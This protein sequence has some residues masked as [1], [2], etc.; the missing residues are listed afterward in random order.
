[1]A[2]HSRGYQGNEKYLALDA[3]AGK[4]FFLHMTH[5]FCIGQFEPRSPERYGNI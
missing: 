2:A 4:T 3:K 1:L 5:S